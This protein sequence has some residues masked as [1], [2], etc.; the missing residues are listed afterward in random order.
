MDANG[1]FEYTCPLPWQYFH[2]TNMPM[3]PEPG[4]TQIFDVPIAEIKILMPKMQED[5]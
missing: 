1:I 4:T 5:N 2:Q 3:L